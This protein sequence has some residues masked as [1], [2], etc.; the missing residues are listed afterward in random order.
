MNE[1]AI[2]RILAATTFAVAAIAFAAGAVANDQV[3]VRFSW[4]LKGEYGPMYLAQEKGYFKKAKLDV[5]LGEGAGAQAALGSLVQG[6]EDVVVLPGIFA[7]S[8][9]QK[10]IPVK[11]VALYHPSTPIVLLSFPDKPVRTPKDLEGKTIATSV[12]ETGTTYLDVFCKLNS[13]DCSK[14]KRVTMNDQARYPNFLQRHVDVVSAY[15]DN[16]LPLIQAKNKTKFVILDMVKYSL[17]VPG[18]SVVTSDA[19]IAKKPDVLRRFLHAVAEGIGAAKKD[20]EAATRAIMKNWPNAPDSKIVLQQ[21]KVTLGAIPAPASHPIG[22]ID[23][24]VIAT[25]LQMM[26][27]TGEIKEPKPVDAYFTNA[28]LKQ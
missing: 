18:M 27:S 26:K 12:G 5:R 13:V 24:K 11:L 22:W 14:I 21:V 6:Q 23:Q 10:G 15:E 3:N 16:D 2:R 28:L 8:A 25:T 7:L 4:K 20:P 9:I 19:N 17:A 1:L